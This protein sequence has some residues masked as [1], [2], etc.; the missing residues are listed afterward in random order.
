MNKFKV[1]YVIFKMMRIYYLN[2]PSISYPT[3][4]VNNLKKIWTISMLSN[5]EEN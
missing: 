4:M 1:N 2:L 3:Q 5:F